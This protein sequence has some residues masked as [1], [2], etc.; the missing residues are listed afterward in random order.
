MMPL[1][2]AELCELG[3]IDRE[4][5]AMERRIR[6]ARFPVTKGLDIFEFMAMPSLNKF[7]AP[8]LAGCE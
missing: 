8:E 7:L 2:V 6:L 1:P 5:R 3:R 4:R